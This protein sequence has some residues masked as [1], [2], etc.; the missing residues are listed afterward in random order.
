MAAP[1]PKPAMTA[2]SDHI[3]RTFTIRMPIFVPPGIFGTRIG[4]GT[5]RAKQMAE[6]NLLKPQNTQQ[7]KSAPDF[8]TGEFSNWLCKL[9]MPPEMFTYYAY[10]S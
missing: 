6:Q 1:K 3:A 5:T 2:T 7:I 10:Y 8:W 4:Y 9:Y